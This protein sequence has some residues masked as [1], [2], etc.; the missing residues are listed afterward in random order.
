MN[1]TETDENQKYQFLISFS[2]STKPIKL[3][4]GI[5]STQ[6]GDNHNFFSIEIHEDMKNLLIVKTIVDG[7]NINL[8]A[9]FSSSEQINKIEE[10]DYSANKKEVSVYIEENQIKQKCSKKGSKVCFIHLKVD[11]S[12]HQLFSIGY[13][14]NSKPF[15]LVKGKA[16][17]G[18]SPLGDNELYFIYH[19]EVKYPLNLSFNTKGR[20]LTI[21][22]KLIETGT[23][24]GE[25][26]LQF[27]NKDDHDK[28]QVDI[29][30][31]VT[32]ILYDLNSLK[33]K[34]SSPEL[35]ISIKGD[36]ISGKNVF[37]KNNPFI[38]QCMT[39]SKEILRT[40][41]HSE[42]V[43][44]ETWNYYNFYNN[45]NSNTLRVYVNSSGADNIDVLLSKG[46]QSRPPFTNKSLIKKSGIGGGN[47]GI[48]GGNSGIG[49]GNS[50]I[51]GGNRAGGRAIGGGLNR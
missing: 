1:D 42:G 8:C 50:G 19:P 6:Y 49:G 44:E 36:G 23:N 20:N 41:T 11:L 26:N 9:T 7:Y 3:N 27:P 33:N 10:C 17:T 48:G 35:L 34:G 37:D 24:Q 22:T 32:N 43:K 2:Y 25:T 14:Y 21:Y 5:I 51:G 4:P 16:F 39:D 46:L 30:G 18:P 31:Y 47:S 28:D 38:L 13:T 40:H 15:N 12:E 29:D 45:G